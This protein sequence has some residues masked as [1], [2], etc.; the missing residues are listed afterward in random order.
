[1][2][3]AGFHTV[4][5]SQ[6][7]SSPAAGVGLA[8]TSSSHSLTPASIRQRRSSRSS[9]VSRWSGAGE[10]VLPPAL[11]PA[12]PAHTGN[13]QMWTRTVRLA[14][15]AQRM[16]EGR[17]SRIGSLADLLL[18]CLDHSLSS[19][20][21]VLHVLVLHGRNNGGENVGKAGNFVGEIRN[22]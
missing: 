8:Q 9:Q 17:L 14:A 3:A 18:Q 4:S 19:F 21:K 13:V 12:S 5:S 15:R 2:M 1:M 6:A 11:S 22:V 10:S 20:A 16:R 7:S